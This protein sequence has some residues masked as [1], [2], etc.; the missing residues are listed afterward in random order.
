MVPIKTV[1]A[2]HGVSWLFGGW[3]NFARNPTIWFLLT[4]TFMTSLMVLLTLGLGG[5]LVALLISP[6]LMSGLLYAARENEE[7]RP[8]LLSHLVQ[9]FRDSRAL[10]RMVA[11]GGVLLVMVILTSLIG[12]ALIGAETMARLNQPGAYPMPELND[13]ALMGLLFIVLVQ[14]A[15]MSAVAYA[16]PLILFRNIP[17]GRAMLASLSVCVRNMLPLLVFSVL[18][19]LI[20]FALA[21]PLLLVCL[22]L[23]SLSALTWFPFLLMW[24]LLPV[25]LAMLYVSYRDCLESS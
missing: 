12:V 25:S 11:L 3:R 14:L 16:V 8:M 19:V 21:F 7:G 6:V 18:Y 15:V 1:S 20:V 24:L 5:V 4:T 22:A 23:F 13:S 2:R 17:A 9:G 10:W